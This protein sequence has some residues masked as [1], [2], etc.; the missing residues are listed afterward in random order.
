MRDL[1]ARV[2]GLLLIVSI[3]G[4]STLQAIPDWANAG[5]S[6]TPSVAPGD[7]L[8]ITTRD[9][10][11]HDLVLK[12]REGDTWV[13]TQVDSGAVV[14]IAGADIL[15]VE[16]REPTMFAYAMVGLGVLSFY[17]LLFWLIDVVVGSGV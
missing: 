9:Q 7:T 16:K 5:E 10:A 14:R 11:R 2:L 15:Q 12:A 17:V 6:T 3:G 13:G 1:F 4:C 8:R